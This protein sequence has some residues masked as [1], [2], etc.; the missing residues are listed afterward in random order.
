MRRMALMAELL[1]GIRAHAFDW[2]LAVTGLVDQ[3]INV[4]TVTTR[5]TLGPKV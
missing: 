3:G 5:A 1:D 2:R 4:P